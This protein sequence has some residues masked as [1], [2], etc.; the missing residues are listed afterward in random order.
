VVVGVTA[1]RSLNQQ[2]PPPVMPGQ[3]GQDM[4]GFIDLPRT[5][6]DLHRHRCC[7]MPRHVFGTEAPRRGSHSISTVVLRTLP[8]CRFVR[9]VSVGT[10]AAISDL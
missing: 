2:R 3:S 4:A 1:G 5:C 10:I 9:G 7:G 6:P 8:P